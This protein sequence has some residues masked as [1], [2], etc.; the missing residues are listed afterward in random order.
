MNGKIFSANDLIAF[1]R[2]I[3]G[4]KPGDIG[5][6]I[7]KSNVEDPIYPLA[8]HWVGN[9]RAINT[10]AMCKDEKNCKCIK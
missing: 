7:M 1:G 8:N 6:S 9:R 3:I 10:K 2:Y 4:L 5:H